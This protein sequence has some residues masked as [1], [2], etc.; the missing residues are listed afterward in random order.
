MESQQRKHQENDLALPSYSQR[1]SHESKHLTLFTNEI[2]KSR[3]VCGRMCTC[4]R[5]TNLFDG[6]VQCIISIWVALLG[7]SSSVSYL[8]CPSST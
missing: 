1:T 6:H 7:I 4:A 2:L 5:S 3:S 8:P